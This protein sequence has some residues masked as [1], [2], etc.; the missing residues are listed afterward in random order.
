MNRIAATNQIMLTI[1]KIA[2]RIETVREL[3]AYTDADGQLDEWT[4]RKME[5]TKRELS[6]FCAELGITDV[7]GN[8]KMADEMVKLNRNIT[9]ARGICA[10]VCSSP[11]DEWLINKHSGLVANINAMIGE[12]GIA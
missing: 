7:V 9:E 8:S 10:S 1:K 11:S 2:N 3:A 5:T 12:I 4:A 6:A